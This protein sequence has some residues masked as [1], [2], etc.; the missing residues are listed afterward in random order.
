MTGGAV[1][2][3]Q[4]PSSRDLFEQMTDI[5]TNYNLRLNGLLTKSEQNKR[6]TDIFSEAPK[7]DK[8]EYGEDNFSLFEC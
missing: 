2:S 5:I 8:E 3:S 1:K 6:A 4:S 7:D